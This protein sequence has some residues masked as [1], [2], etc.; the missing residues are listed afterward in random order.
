MRFTPTLVPTLAA[1]IVIALMLK[2][3]FWQLHRAQEKEAIQQASELF[4]S[5]STEHP[6]SFTELLQQF[7]KIDT[8]ANEAHLQIR[9][10]FLPS[11]I[12]LHDNRMNE[13][14]AGYH[15][16]SLFQPEGTHVALLIN[17]GWHS[18][19]NGDR[20]N[21]PTLQ[22][23]REEQTLRGTI[24]VPVKG[25]FTLANHADL[26]EPHFVLVQ[27]LELNHLSE[28]LHHALAPFVLQLDANS[29]PLKPFDLQ[30][31]WL[32]ANQVGMTPEKHRG[33][34]FQWFIMAAV[35]FGL[36]VKLNLKKLAA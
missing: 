22:V 2:L 21:R 20:S 11:R 16:L 24:H 15:V 26:I 17:H 9:G 6:L 27:T 34:A 3:G 36:Y 33:Y 5:R 13:G 7:S 31:H 25:V 1:I 23:P 10:H 35:V 32:Q 30:R 14:H 4:R 8:A 19:P 18:W 12:I 29:P 28:L